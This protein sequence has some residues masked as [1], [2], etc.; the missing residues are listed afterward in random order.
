MTNNIRHIDFKHT[1]LTEG[2]WQKRQQINRDVIIHAI[3][4]RFRETGRFD[5]L[6]LEWKEG[7]PNKPHIFWDSDIA[8]WIESAAFIL[9]KGYVPELE[10]KIDETVDLIE[11]HQLPDG[12]FN[13]CFML[14]EPENRFTRKTD[15][16]LYC[17]GHFIE[18][19]VA[20]Y[21]ATG[22]D[23][24]LNIVLSYVDCIERCFVIEKTA[25]FN[26]PGH[27][28]IELALI[29][30]YQV[31]GDQRHLNLAR[32]FI[33][34]RGTDDESSFYDF[35]GAKYSQEH[36][37]IREQTTAEGHSVRAG[38]LYAGM[39][40]LAKEINDTALLQACKAIYEDIV[41]KKMYITGGI[42]SEAHGEAFTMSYDLLNLTAYA[43][44]CAAISLA[45]FARRMLLIDAQSDYADTIERVIYNGFLSSVSLDGTAFFYV[46]PLEIDPSLFERH[47]YLHDKNP[48][49][50]IATRKAVFDCSCCPPNIC[51]FIASIADYLYT[52][53]D[54]TLFIHQYMA[55]HSEFQINGSDISIEQ[56]TDYPNSGSINIHTHGMENK[57]IAVRIPGWCRSYTVSVNGALICPEVVN[58]YAMIDCNN[59]IDININFEMPVTLWE[60]HPGVRCDAGRVAVQRGPVVYCLEGVDNGDRL[61]DIKVD[62]EN[63]EQAVIQYEK[64]FGTY[65]LKMDGFRRNEEEFDA[66]YRPQSYSQ[67]PC[68]LTF[69]PYFA[70]A[71]R[72]ETE[73]AVWINI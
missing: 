3:E 38:Y 51:R 40:D 7:M 36:L 65:I 33:D 50:P 67:M 68:K 48:M 58:H 37:P 27:E 20:Y 31:T 43:E 6:R 61:W 56:I 16:E 28:E 12:Y 11:L 71:N 8:K 9:Q 69:I 41:K 4:S 49:L 14:F 63:I 21:N 30:L 54:D 60:A 10:Q 23:K 34:V 64:Q 44:S 72:G 19:A 2:F 32:H 45:M 53:S 59:D 42:G 66:L 15:H 70:F 35:A 46:N 39:A 13:I 24:L 26:A 57:K 22:K 25:K 47:D 52:A 18:A 62:T 29:K 1:D 73:M 55:S 5:A 17:A